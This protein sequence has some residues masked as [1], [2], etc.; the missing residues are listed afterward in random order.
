MKIFIFFKMFSTFLPPKTLESAYIMVQR[1]LG[2]ANQTWIVWSR[3]SSS[4]TGAY[5]TSQILLL[6]LVDTEF[7]V[8]LTGVYILQSTQACFVCAGTRSY[9]NSCVMYRFSLLYL[10]PNLSKNIVNISEQ[11]IE[12]SNGD[13]YFPVFFIKAQCYNIFYG[14]FQNREIY[15]LQLVF[16]LLIMIFYGYRYDAIYCTDILLQVSTFSCL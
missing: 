12:V 9:P 5:C 3:I 15:I 7:S 14:F 4:V 2:D 13:T 11:E 6:Y 1:W 16:T 8:P 10:Y